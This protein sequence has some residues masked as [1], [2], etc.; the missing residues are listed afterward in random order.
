[1]VPVLVVTHDDKELKAIRSKLD[2]FLKHSK[3][4]SDQVSSEDDETELRELRAHA[5]DLK[6]ELEQKNIEI[7]V[8]QG[9]IDR[10]FKSLADGGSKHSATGSGGSGGSKSALDQALAEAAMYKKKIAELEK[11]IALSKI[12]EKS[13]AKK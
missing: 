4:L 7:A 11:Q 8:L 5:A 10:T 6:K 3:G 9:V 1:M 2:D 12:N 13:A